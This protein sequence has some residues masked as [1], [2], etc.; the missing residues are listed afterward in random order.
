M[1]SIPPLCPFPPSFAD[2]LSLPLIWA[3]RPP[4]CICMSTVTVPDEVSS[5]HAEVPNAV[6]EE[7]L[8]LI[9]ES[10]EHDIRLYA[11]AQDLF[12]KAMVQA[13]SPGF[14]AHFKRG[15]AL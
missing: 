14:S 10:N 2:F 13:R 6:D 4:E 1:F 5:G 15:P 12:E 11:A 3:L 9:Q 8:Q 7:M